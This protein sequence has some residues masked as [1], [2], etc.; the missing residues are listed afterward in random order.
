[1]RQQKSSKCSNGAIARIPLH[2]TIIMFEFS[3]QMILLLNWYAV[4][5][6]DGGEG[7][8]E[9][10]YFQKQWNLSMSSIYHFFNAVIFRC[11][12]KFLMPTF[13]LCL[14][15]GGAYVN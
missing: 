3:S 12:I 5:T 15:G 14:N 7:T 4:K 9:N 1:M 11:R 2:T 8:Q 6:W 13:C 10:S